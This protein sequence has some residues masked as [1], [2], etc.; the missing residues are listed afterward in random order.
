VDWTAATA[1][2]AAH[3]VPKTLQACEV[4]HIFGDADE[5]LSNSHRIGQ[6]R[7]QKAYRLFQDH[8]INRYISGNNF[9][10]MSPQLTAQV[11]KPFTDDRHVSEVKV[12]SLEH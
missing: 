8:T 11:S 5:V 1:V 12:S 2:K 6:S 10:K 4:A 9:Q 3:I 7:P